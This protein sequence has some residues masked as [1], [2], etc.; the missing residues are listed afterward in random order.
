MVLVSPGVECL[1]QRRDMRNAFLIPA[2]V[3][4]LV[5]APA[6]NATAAESFRRAGAEFNALRSVMVPSGKGYTIAV[7]EFF[8]HGEIRP[9]G[10]NVLVIAK[11][12]KEMAPMRVLQLGPGDFCRV[13]FQTVK[14][15]AEYELLYGGDPPKESPP[16]WSRH[17]GLL[18]E[19][20]QFKHC[21]LNSLESVCK[22]FE[23][24]PPIGADYVDGVFHCGQS[25]Y[26]E[27]RTVP[28]PLQRT[29]APAEVRHVR[30]LHVEPG[31]QLPLDRRQ[32][33]GLR[34]RP[35]RPAV[36]GAEGRSPR[37]ETSSRTAHLRVLPCGRRGLRDDGR[38]LRGRSRSEAEATGDDSL[39]SVRATRFA[40]CWPATSACG[41]R[42]SCLTSW[43][44]LSATCPCPTTTSR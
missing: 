15:Q 20:R 31:L 14:G 9:D 16:A 12:S 17:E 29:T 1:G 34:A 18:L 7:A 21:D 24:A 36:R 43:R 8:H 44:R 4:V 26:A 25:V 5:L 3:T 37:R 11:N 27:A 19:A 28:Q 42:S 40:T 33:G 32:G 6:T 22:A 35:S 41:R 2:C 23:S 38:R 30:L 10:S 13:A 39:R